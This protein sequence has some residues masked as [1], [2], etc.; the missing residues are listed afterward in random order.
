MTQIRAGILGVGFMGGAHTEA[1]R[2]L[3]GTE[4]VAVADVDSGKARRVAAALAIPTVH[5]D[6][7]ALIQDP[8]IDVVH[9]CTPNDAHLRLNRAA[10]EAGKH[11]ISEKP[12]G[13]DSSETRLLL[14]LAERTGRVAAV[15]FGYRYFPLPQHVRAAVQSDRYGKVLL[16]HGQYLQD[17]LLY[18]RDY[19]W[20]IDPKRGGASRAVADI[21]SHWCDLVQH[22]T[23]LQIVRVCADLGPVHAVRQRHVTEVETFADAGAGATVEVP[24][25]TEDYAAVLLEFSGGIRGTFFVSQVS[26]G[27]KNG[28]VFEVDCAQASLRWEQE[29]SNS[30]W[31]GY[32]DKANE[33]LA[34][35]PGLLADAAKGYA[36]YPGGHGEGYPDGIKNL[37]RNVYARIA[38]GSAAPEYPTFLE[39]HRIALLVEAIL[40]SNQKRCWVD[41]P[42]A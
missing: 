5:E 41:V 36:S 27:H 31:I 16:V 12:L 35:D 32:G 19:N 17:W 42:A 33:R 40:A 6:P 11:L 29:D 30:L 22:V 38:D 18:A 24:V 8:R 20:R 3:P 28:L 1:I 10:L 25:E 2:R 15:N 39:A 4:V 26:A 37:L 34:K 23:G 7:M 21:G 14:D 9:N 13:L